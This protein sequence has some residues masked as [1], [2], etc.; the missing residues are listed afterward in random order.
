MQ[1]K[2]SRRTLAQVAPD[3]LLTFGNS[4]T[5]F[6]QTPGAS[7][8]EDRN[9]DLIDRLAA[10]DPQTTLD[11]LLESPFDEPW[12]VPLASNPPFEPEP[13]D[14]SEDQTFGTDMIGAVRLGHPERD[15][16][17]GLFLV[18]PDAARA[19]ETFQQVVTDRPE[20]RVQSLTLAG[21]DAAM[22]LFGERTANVL[23]RA[24]YVVMVS[25]DDILA[26]GALTNN[27]SAQIRALQHALGLTWHL[28][29][30]L[31]G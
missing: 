25:S 1:G 26:D 4:T 13:Y 14:T 29:R 7:E 15:V 16:G 6:A 11:L 28:F 31:R 24:D 10:T 19:T 30:T 20:E 18:F 2:V 5:S 3:S 12:L 23:V 21:L 22:G 17:V 27:F 9:P 8:D